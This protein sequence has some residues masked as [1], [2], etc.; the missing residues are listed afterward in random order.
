MVQW[1][2]YNTNNK[3]KSML[4]AGLLFSASLSS[5]LKEKL[6]KCLKD[7][8]TR[9]HCAEQLFVGKN[10]QQV[11]QIRFSWSR[12]RFGYKVTLCLISRVF[13]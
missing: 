8:L 6:N 5:H 1:I 12:N 2:D 9:E 3:K 11:N 7:D 13:T 10:P 4:N